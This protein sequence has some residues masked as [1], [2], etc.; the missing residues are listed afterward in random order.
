MP[1]ET[2]NE[3]PNENENDNTDLQDLASDAIGLASWFDSSRAGSGDVLTLWA[4]VDTLADDADFTER[5]ASTDKKGKTTFI[6]STPTEDRYRSI[7]VQDWKLANYRK[8]PVI[9]W[10][11]NRQTPPIGRGVATVKGRN[12]ETAHLSIEVE[13]DT[14]PTNPLGMAVASQYA[15][16]FLH[17]GS[18]G[19]E[20]GEILDRSKLPADHPHYRAPL[21]GEYGKLAYRYS[22]NELH[23]FSGVSVPG[24]ADA[25]ALRD[26]ALRAEDPKEQAVRALREAMTRADAAVVLDALAHAPDALKTSIRAALGLTASAAH[27]PMARSKSGIALDFFK[28]D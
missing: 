3:M 12:S 22:K 7:I 10:S 6:A 9:L 14:D 16:G 25:V 23:E 2:P 26:Y 15:R 13:W 27:V 28:R 20:A 17:A 19:W 5:A 8:N 11:H 21:A 1:N 24:N 4:P 18:V